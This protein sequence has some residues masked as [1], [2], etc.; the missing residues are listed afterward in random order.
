MISTR[1]QIIEMLELK[2]YLST[3][4]MSHALKL[5]PANI[6]HHLGILEQEGVIEVA[7]QRK[8]HGK[9]R[10]IKIY[11]LSSQILSNNLD[12]LAAALLEELKH[13]EIS[14]FDM[15]IARVASRLARPVIAPNQSLTRRLFLTIQRL[16][17]MHY[18]ARWEAHADS[19]R[20]YL[21]HCP[22]ANILPE[23]PE[24]CLMDK[25][26]LEKL[27]DHPVIQTAKLEKDDHGIQ[28]CLFRTIK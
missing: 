15:L 14:I 8:T 12:G 3:P 13:Y 22:Y 2:K 7:S 28:Y 16:N 24:L 20:I 9:G 26:I 4:E 21:E 25:C 23:H 18:Q 6:R 11:T 10:P 17:D 5:T 27:L 1:Q 19:P